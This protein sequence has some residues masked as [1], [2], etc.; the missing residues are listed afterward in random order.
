MRIINTRNI[1]SETNIDGHLNC[2]HYNKETETYHWWE[3]IY[4]QPKLSPQEFDNHTTKGLTQLIRGRGMLD[5]VPLKDGRKRKKTMRLQ[6][7]LIPRIILCRLLIL[8]YIRNSIYYYYNSIL[9]LR[10]FVNDTSGT[11][12]FIFG[13]E[14]IF[15]KNTINKKLF[16]LRETISSKNMKMIY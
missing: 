16:Y 14:F 9:I 4:V 7:Y 1:Y 10:V 11:Q 2:R 5:F 6:C 3:V 13:Y 12:N 8:K 15:S